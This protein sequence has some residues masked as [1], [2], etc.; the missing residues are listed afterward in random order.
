MSNNEIHRAGELRQI[1]VSQSSLLDLEQIGHGTFSPLKG[2]MDKETL[3]CVLDNH[4]LPN[5]SVWT[6]PVLLQLDKDQSDDI[7]IGQEI[8]LTDRT[9]V[10]HG[11]LNISDKFSLNL[12][13]LA[14]RWFSTKSKQHPGVSKLLQ[15]GNVCVGGE[16]KYARRPELTRQTYQL[17]PAETRFI[18][19]H[20][21]QNLFNIS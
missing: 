11:T 18:F 19:N 6:M 10:I 13:Q 2:F 7:E 1:V 4:M 3:E 5:G 20:K 14:N 15:S 16:I 8:A 9:G 17:T 21:G 12:E